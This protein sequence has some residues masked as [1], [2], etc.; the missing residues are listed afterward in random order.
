M[1]ENYDDLNQKYFDGK[2]GLCDF[3]L[4]TKGKFSN[5]N[6]IGMFGSKVKDVIKIDDKTRQLSLIENGREIPITKDNFVELFKPVIRLNGNYK[7]FEKSWLNTLIH[8]MCHYY[9]YMNGIAPKF[10]HK[11]EF[12]EISQKIFDKSNGE[13][14]INTKTS[15]DEMEVFEPTDE[16]KKKMKK[17]ISNLVACFVFMENGKIRLSLTSDEDVLENIVL[18]NKYDSIQN[19]QKISKIV[20]SN[21][22]ELLEIL[23]KLG[24]RRDM[25]T[26]KRF[27][28]INKRIGNLVFDYEYETI[29]ESLLE[30]SGTGSLVITSNMN[31]CEKSPFEYNVRL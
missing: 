19:T 14:K 17:K 5:G 2:L 29:S 21:D 24:Y 4:S 10:P 16:L 3:E 30:S 31:L 8:E 28:V 1:K 9:T 11:E 18:N 25:K 22:P 7:A 15:Y 27:W 6:A 26:A 12:K 23:F 20:I 13:F